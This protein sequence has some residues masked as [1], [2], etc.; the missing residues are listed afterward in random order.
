M[1]PPPRLLPEFLGDTCLG[2]E[3]RRLD[4]QGKN[5]IETALIDVIEPLRNV[6][7]GVVDERIQSGERGDQR[8]GDV[9]VS[10][11]SVR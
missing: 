7:S 2:D 10:L 3:K 4:V 9:R 5:R 8:S 11:T 1:A 6:V